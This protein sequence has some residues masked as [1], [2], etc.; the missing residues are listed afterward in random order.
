MILATYGGGTNSSAAIIE[1]VKR[2]LSIDVILFADT[3]AKSHTLTVTLR[4]LVNG[5]CRKA[6]QK[7]SL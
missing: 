3:G 6:T 4:F 5:W 1:W 2:K 7:S